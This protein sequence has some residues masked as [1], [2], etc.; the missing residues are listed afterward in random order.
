LGQRNKFRAPDAASL[1]FL[2]RPWAVIV[3]KTESWIRAGRAAKLSHRLYE[4]MNKSP[5]IGRPPLGIARR[6]SGRIA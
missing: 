5:G 1:A 3:C 4:F 6:P 2:K